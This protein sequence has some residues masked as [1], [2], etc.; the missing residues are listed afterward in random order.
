MTVHELAVCQ[1]LLEHVD[2]IASDHGAQ[3]VV[4]VHLNIGPL[5]G[6]EAPLLERAFSIARVGTT[7]ENAELVTTLTRAC[8]HCSACDVES[9]VSANRLL[10]PRCGDWRTRLV[11]GDELELARIEMNVPDPN[12]GGDAI[13][14]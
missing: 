9:F 1:S 3:E 11:G 12:R 2:R 8:V 5:S 10:C 4:A 13:H 7:A 6:I 14:V